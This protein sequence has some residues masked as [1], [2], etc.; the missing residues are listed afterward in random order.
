M[1]RQS[2]ELERRLAMATNLITEQTKR[3]KK[4]NR[5]KRELREMRTQWNTQETINNSLPYQHICQ[6]ILEWTTTKISPV[7]YSN[8]RLY[9]LSCNAVNLSAHSR[10]AL[11]VTI[12]LQQF[13]RWG[14]S[15][16]KTVDVIE[17]LP[18]SCVV[19]DFLS[20][21]DRFRARASTTAATDAEVFVYHGSKSINFHRIIENGFKVGG[22]STEYPII[23]GSTYGSGVYSSINPQQAASYNYSSKIL[24]LSLGLQGNKTAA[25]EEGSDSWE[26]FTNMI[27]FASGSQLLPRYLLHYE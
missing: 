5:V 6:S 3:L 19:A 23:H 27:V 2:R 14:F 1:K 10:E 16:L 12:A 26:P 20:M 21:R 17:Y 8:Y 11:E 18:S 15:K 7:I 9:T 4:L 13:N 24:L 22:S 25:K